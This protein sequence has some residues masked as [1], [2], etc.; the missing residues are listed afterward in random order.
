MQNYGKLVDV[1]D[2]ELSAQFNVRRFG[3]LEPPEASRIR[4]V[5]ELI[6]DEV[7]SNFHLEPR[8]TYQPNHL[9]TGPA[10]DSD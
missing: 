1:I 4:L 2:E 5:S 3:D 8:E 6:A 7:L 10:G 9:A